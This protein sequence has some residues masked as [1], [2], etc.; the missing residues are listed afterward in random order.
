MAI[1]LADEHDRDVPWA[2]NRKEAKDHG[3]G[4]VLVGAPLAGPGAGGRRRDYRGHGGSRGDRY[5]RGRG[6]S[7]AGVAI[8]LDRQERGQGE[9]SAIQEIEQEFGCRWSVLLTSSN[10]IEYLD[11][12]TRG[13]KYYAAIF[14]S[15]CWNTDHTT[16][17]DLCGI[18]AN[19]L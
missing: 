8:G 2:Y 13:W 11:P 19:I 14:E 16:A 15:P 6:G 9:L 4:G 12:V 17:C 18:G 3:E 10:L 5:D 1:A 7:C